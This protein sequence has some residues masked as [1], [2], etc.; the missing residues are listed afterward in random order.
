M[1]WFEA[2]KGH[3]SSNKNEYHVPFGQD[4]IGKIKTQVCNVVRRSGY[5]KGPWSLNRLQKTN[6]A[7]MLGLLSIQSAYNYLRLLK[8]TIHHWSVAA[9]A[10][11]PGGVQN[12]LLIITF[13][14][15]HF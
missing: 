14:H 9:L 1:L 10:C 13:T 3:K 5:E 2:G 8:D 7:S 6:F 12:S 11:A 15:I 4:R